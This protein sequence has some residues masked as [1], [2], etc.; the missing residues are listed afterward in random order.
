MSPFHFPALDLFIFGICQQQTLLAALEPEG[1]SVELD[2]SYHF[3]VLGCGSGMFQ[4]AWA[5]V[6]I[7]WVNADGTPV[8]NSGTR[9]AVIKGD[10]LSDER[11][12]YK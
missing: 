8:A 7:L 1:D 9:F 3:S 5:L 11:T 2:F 10:L 4:D 12:Y 6:E